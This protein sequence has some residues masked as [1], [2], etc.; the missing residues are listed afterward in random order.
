MNFEDDHEAVTRLAD[1]A[2]PRCACHIVR[3]FRCNCGEVH[4]DY[5]ENC[6]R[7]TACGTEFTELGVTDEICAHGHA[8]HE[9]THAE[10]K[11]RIARWYEFLKEHRP[12][13][14]PNDLNE[15]RRQVETLAAEYRRAKNSNA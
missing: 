11:S 10:K 14:P 8:M 6:G 9:H 1:A 3:E 2:C 13:I 5:C 4:S 7:F 15:A 12:S